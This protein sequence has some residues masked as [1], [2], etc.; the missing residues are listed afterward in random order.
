MPVGP[1]SAGTFLV[2]VTSGQ[3]CLLAGYY[4]L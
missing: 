3:I 1:G 4:I 2:E